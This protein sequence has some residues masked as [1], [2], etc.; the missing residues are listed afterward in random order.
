MRSL[1][2]IPT[3]SCSRRGARTPWRRCARAKGESR[4]P[5]CTGEG[6]EE[7]GETSGANRASRRI[8]P[9]PRRFFCRLRSARRS[10]HGA[11]ERHL[12]FEPHTQ[13]C[14]RQ[15]RGG[16]RG[17]RA[18][19]SSLLPLPVPRLSFRAPRSWDSAR[20]QPRHVHGRRSVRAET[21]GSGS[22]PVTTAHRRVFVCAAASMSFQ[23][24]SSRRGVS[25]V[26]FS[27]GAVGYS[28]RILRSASSRLAA[29]ERGATRL[30]ARRNTPRLRTS[31]SRTA[32][33]PRRAHG[34]HAEERGV[35]LAASC[36]RYRIRS[37][38][39][40]AASSPRV[41]FRAHRPRDDAHR[42]RVRVPE[43]SRVPGT[44]SVAAACM[45]ILK[46]RV[47]RMSIS[48]MRIAAETRAL[49]RRVVVAEQRAHRVARVPL[50]LRVSRRQ[51]RHER[52]NHLRS[53]AFGASA[54]SSPDVASRNRTR[55][56]DARGRARV[57]ANLIP[58]R[59]AAP[60]HA[61]P[62]DVVGATT[63]R[64]FAVASVPPP[65]F[66]SPRSGRRRDRVGRRPG[67][68]LAVWRRRSETRG[69]PSRS[70][71]GSVATSPVSG[72]SAIGGNAPSAPSARRRRA[73]R[74]DGFVAQRRVR[75][76]NQRAAIFARPPRR[77]RHE[78]D[79]A[80]E[81]GR[82][83]ERRRVC[84]HR[85]ELRGRDV[86]PERD[87]L[88]ARQRRE[89]E[90]TPGVAKPRIRPVHAAGSSSPT[91]D[92]APPPP[93]ASTYSERNRAR[94]A[95]RDRR[96]RRF[97]GRRGG[98]RGGEDARVRASH[99]AATAEK[100]VAAAAQCA[101]RFTPRRRAE[102][103]VARDVHET[104]DDLREVRKRRRRTR[105]RLREAPPLRRRRRFRH[106]RARAIP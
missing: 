3:R 71:S 92:T 100:C 58:S 76:V 96:R 103:R 105:S 81:T 30:I 33:R 68:S 13:G 52:L 40:A 75:R 73:N 17:V 94:L 54:P 101:V 95:R 78:P 104:R 12:V 102:T 45:R 57:G 61:P 1:A 77:R 63:R 89:R 60:T 99:A 50:H 70:V 14:V 97:G 91:A 37:A 24:S 48:S 20:S 42:V 86:V 79:E 74:G 34:E 2:F 56:R 90:P 55:R 106:P 72:S 44:P 36:G 85:G 22:V 80:P 38:S 21:A 93:A 66:A 29:L 64:G 59:T 28:E 32:P 51:A 10:R 87:E 16:R 25:R 53:H 39:P 41:E 43:L 18:R 82:A 9:S 7:S 11:V 8:V 67:G 83:H 49:R 46:L 19:S 27:P 88:C 47:S 26:S 5:V 31:V 4:A 62:R 15:P 65:E 35:S 84:G 69:A 98:K 6:S 23:I